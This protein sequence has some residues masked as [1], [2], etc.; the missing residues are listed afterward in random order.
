MSPRPSFDHHRESFR[1]ISG[2]FAVACSL[3]GTAFATAG[4][5]AADVPDSSPIIAEIVVTAQKRSERLQDVPI[6]VSSISGAQLDSRGV[7]ELADL[8][9]VV[10]GIS[11]SSTLNGRGT[12]AIRGVS[13]T[14]EI[15]TVEMFID[16]IPIFA[17]SN[18]V[19]GAANPDV[20]DIDH[21]EVLKG[22]QGTLYGGSSMGGA[23]KF[24]TR[25]PDVDRF[26]IDAA[27]EGSTTRD[28]DPSYEARTTANLPL[29]PG[30][31]AFRAS[32]LYRD[33]GGFVDRVAHGEALDANHA[34][35]DS[36]GMAIGLGADG[37][38][39]AVDPQTGYATSVPAK[40]SISLNSLSQENIDDSRRVAA[41]ASL[42]YTPTDSLSILPAFSYQRNEVDEFGY[43]WGNLPRFQMSGR[44]PEAGR[45]GMKLSSLTLEKT[46]GNTALTSI[47]S[48]RERGQ[49]FHTDSSFYIGGVVEAFAALPSDTFVT[50]QFQYKTQEIRLASTGDT[51]FRWTTGVF[52]AEDKNHFR[53]TITTAGVSSDFGI[54]PLHGVPDVV[55]ATTLKKSLQQYAVFGEASYAL[56]SQLDLTLGVRG[57]KIEQD[58]DRMVEG[59]LTTPFAFQKEISEDGVTPKASLAYKFTRDNM[60]YVSATK[61]FRA[62]G[63]N[64]GV[65]EDLC[66][67]DLARLGR[68]RSPNEYESDSLWNYEIGSKNRIAEGRVTLNAAA[69]YIDWSKLQQ[70]VFLP[71]CGFTFTANAGEARS[72]GAE[73]ELQ[74]ALT[75]GFTVGAAVTRTDAEITSVLPGA[76]A[77]AGDRVLTTP[78]WILQ[79]NAE[80]RFAIGSARSL[81]IRGDY[82]YRSDQWRSFNRYLCR[83]APG[84]V[85]DAS[86]PACPNADEVPVADLMQVQDG[87]GSAN[88]AIGIE[89]DRWSAQLFINNLLDDQPVID[90]YTFDF[91]ERQTTLRPRTIGLRVQTSF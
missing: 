49:A 68:T 21:V 55:Y 13:T 17:R 75:A 61:G 54:P 38:P 50:S 70:Q 77:S 11:F 58:I 52:Y 69:F 80:Y 22:P 91:V 53:F 1:S 33:S 78:K 45:D 18:E 83:I 4:A 31:L 64:N 42:L 81:F 30:K 87:Y 62:G 86:R 84:A 63:T 57:F 72:K 79:A 43:F 28:G 74:A 46:F 56:T 37:R 25:R 51:P 60:V 44:T 89:A 20:L 85:A 8:P 14:T 10:P 26:S 7:K 19:T 65:P 27:A 47:S 88:A 39:L 16:D 2:S 35:T 32:G 82:Q 73:A 41:Q 40:T 36:A 76:G 15:P 59:A 90:Y 3:L 29:I 9:N 66:A 71:G 23:I 24:I 6:A 34:A 12:Y 5:H 48:Y 67:G